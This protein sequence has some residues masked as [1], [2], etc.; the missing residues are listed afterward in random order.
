VKIFLFT[1]KD[2]GSP[3]AT[4]STMVSR[5]FL[6]FMLAQAFDG[7]VFLRAVLHSA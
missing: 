3:S 6:P 1:E 2:E 5:M 4:V 7:R